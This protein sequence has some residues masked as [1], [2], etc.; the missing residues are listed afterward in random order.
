[1]SGSFG[2]TLDYH[3]YL[4][5]G[6]QLRPEFN[7]NSQE[8]PRET[9]R[10]AT[11]PAGRATSAWCVAADTPYPVNHAGLTLILIRICA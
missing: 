2:V 6:G 1:M 8:L 11:Y 4:W 9:T 5:L 7:V 10:S 3:R